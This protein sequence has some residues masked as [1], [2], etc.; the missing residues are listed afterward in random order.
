MIRGG[1]LWFRGKRHCGSIVDP[2]PNIRVGSTVSTDTRETIRR[3]ET[4]ASLII[5]IDRKFMAAVMIFKLT[6]QLFQPLKGHF[7]I[8]LSEEI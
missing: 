5:V 6:N 3:A 8:L 7:P 2:V 1:G 4:I